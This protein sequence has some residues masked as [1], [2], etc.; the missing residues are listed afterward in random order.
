MICA[1]VPALLREDIDQSQLAKTISHFSEIPDCQVFVVAQENRAELPSDVKNVVTLHSPFAL[2]KWGAIRRG[3][4]VVDPSVEIAV[5]LDAD[6]PISGGS[7]RHLV[8]AARKSRDSLLI[9]QRDSILLRAEDELSPCSRMFVELFLNTLL[10]AKVRCEPGSTC[11]ADI[12]S[13]IYALPL[14]ALRTVETGVVRNY[15]GELALFAHA[16]KSG[17]PISSLPVHSTA[18]VRTSYRLGLIVRE[19]LSLPFFGTVTTQDLR[20]AIDRTPVLYPQYL[21][22]ALKVQFFTEISTLVP[23]LQA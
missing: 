18:N 23:Q 4:M 10:L 16:V 8:E 11:A 3:L 6:D 5:L 1:I 2:T 17:M 14:N 21:P 12:Q 19:A 7:V 20:A 15:G 13:G 9:G 22:G